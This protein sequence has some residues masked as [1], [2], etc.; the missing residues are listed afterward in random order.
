MIAPD[1]CGHVPAGRLEH[2]IM[3]FGDG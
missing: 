2:L 3:P 1:L